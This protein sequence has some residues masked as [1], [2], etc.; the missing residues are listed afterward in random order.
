[1][2]VAAT[3]RCCGSPR[4]PECT[5]GCKPPCRFRDLEPGASMSSSWTSYVLGSQIPRALG[6]APVVPLHGTH[7]SQEDLLHLNSQVARKISILLV[8]W[9]RQ[10]RRLSSTLPSSR[11]QDSKTP[12]LKD[13]GSSRLQGS[14]TSGALLTV[15]C[16]S[17]GLEESP[18]GGRTIAQGQGK[19][20]SRVPQGRHGS[21]GACDL[22]ACNLAKRR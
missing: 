15:V 21:S 3:F 17:V 5:A 11:P 8:N 12:S 7:C 20:K 10:P 18:E 22:R 14:K 19:Q 9:S 1:M 4:T 2:Q 13:F 6:F 16:A